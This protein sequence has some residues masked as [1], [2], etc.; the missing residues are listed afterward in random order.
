MT[1]ETYCKACQLDRDLAKLKALR[2]ALER[3]KLITIV[4]E[5]DHI[6]PV[7]LVHLS[8]AVR[9]PFVSELTEIVN[10]YIEKLETE[11]TEL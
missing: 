4:S 8:D 3:P 7:K 6:D 1:N 2:D 10:S 11:F 9:E 5:I